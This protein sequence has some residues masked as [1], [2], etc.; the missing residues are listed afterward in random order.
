MHASTKCTQPVSSL[1]TS[2]QPNTNAPRFQLKYPIKPELGRLMSL[3]NRSS[4]HCPIYYC[5]LYPV[6]I[7]I[8]PVISAIKPA[9]AL[10]TI[11]QTLI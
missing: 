4:Q 3:S 8:S 6:Q 9:A 5:S 2:D 1:L 11:T 10:F 7:V